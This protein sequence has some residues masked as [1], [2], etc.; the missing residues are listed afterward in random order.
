VVRPSIIVGD[1]RTGEIDRMDGPYYLVRTI[2]NF[3]VDVHIPLPGGGTYPLNMVP[4]DFVA[5][6]ADVISRDPNAA[7]KTYHLTDP[8]PMSARRVFEVVA[9]VAGRKRP[10][11]MIPSLAYRY[12]F[13]LP[14]V[15]SLLR[16]QRHFVEMFNQLTI[17]NCMNTLQC[18]AGTG[19]QCPAFPSYATALVGYVQR[20]DHERHESAGAARAGEEAE[21]D[22]FY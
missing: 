21:E 2:V 18:L 9:D 13:R 16:P 7:G 19:V 1:S 12:L 20:R 6:A 3:P 14:Y 11:G 8:N 22:A 4:V 15:E 17:Y 10:K 5:A